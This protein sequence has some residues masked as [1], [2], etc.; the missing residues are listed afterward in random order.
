MMV[1]L[2]DWLWLVVNNRRYGCILVYYRFNFLCLV[3]NE[4]EMSGEWLMKCFSRFDY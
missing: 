4:Y 1:F 3:R 2:E